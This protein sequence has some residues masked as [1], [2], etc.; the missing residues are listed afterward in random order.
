MYKEPWCDIKEFPTRHAESLVSELITEF[1]DQN[2]DWIKSSIELLAKREDQD[3]ILITSEGKFYI[4]HL[5]WS[6]RSEQ[7]PYPIT[8]CYES[9][10]QVLARLSSDS[11]QYEA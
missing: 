4:I 8:S 1:S 5:T 6:G 7:A 10:E 9:W 11:D 2:V 3:E